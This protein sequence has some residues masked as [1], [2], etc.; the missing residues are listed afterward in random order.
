[1]NPSSHSPCYTC[2]S[3]RIQCD[4]SGVPCGKCEKAGLQCF[5]KRPIRWVKGVAIRGKMQGRSYEPKNGASTAA[6]DSDQ[7]SLKSRRVAVKPTHNKIPYAPGSIPVAVQDP[8]ISSLDQ[9]SRY[10]VDYYNDRIC[11]LFIVYD[12]DRNPFR[13]L[14][15]LG[16]TDPVLMKAL[17]ALAARH[18]ANAGQPFDRPDVTTSPSLVNANRDALSFKHQAMEALSHSLRCTELSK[19]DTTVASIFLLIFLDLLESGSDGW[20]FHLEGAKNLIASTYPQ[21]DSQ[22]GINHGPGQTVQEIRA[23]ITKQIHLIETLGATFL[24]PR[25]L[26]QFSSLNQQELRVQETIEKAFLGCPEYMLTAIQCLSM[27]RDSISGVKPLDDTTI[28][29]HMAETASL[30][31]L[32]DNF[33]SYAWASSLQYSR[34]SS[35]QKIANLCKLSQAY[36]IGTLLYGQRILDALTSEVTVQDDKL[37]ELLGLI[38]SLKDDQD[39]FKCV[40]WPVFVAGLECRWQAQ[41]DFLIGSLE[42]FWEITRCLNAVNAAKTL[43]GYWEQVG[44]P[45]EAPSQWIFDIGRLGRDWLWI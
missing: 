36:K 7:K 45:S 40:L 6:H 5:D 25:L 4:Q 17:L 39:M 18:H 14:I 43:R 32:I 15:S 35:P 10:Y 37:S 34:D 31:T 41:R 42:R 44:L 24:R 29:S 27:Q 33:D 19:Q 12:S 21:T 38:D 1:M 26:S 16:L 2:R 9:V 28:H 11:K 13:S 23:F 22:A 3:R 30:L 8:T 20:N